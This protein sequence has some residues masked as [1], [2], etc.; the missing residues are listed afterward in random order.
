MIKIEVQLTFLKCCNISNSNS[1]ILAVLNGFSRWFAFIQANIFFLKGYL[2]YKMITSLNVSSE[3]QI[4]N[5]FNFLEKLCSVL[6]IFKF[7][8]LIYQICDVMMSI[9]ST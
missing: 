5:F 3:A 8:Y 4:K 2:R 1:W 9:I 7:L 6:K